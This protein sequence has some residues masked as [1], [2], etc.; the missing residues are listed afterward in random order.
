MLDR[1]EVHRD[2]EKIT[3]AWGEIDYVFP[4]LKGAR[5]HAGD[6]VGVI[7]HGASGLRY[8]HI[9]LGYKD[10]PEQRRG[11]AFIYEDSLLAGGRY[12]KLF[13]SRR[14][15]IP[16]DRW[17]YHKHSPLGRFWFCFRPK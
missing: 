7:V 14:C 12:E 5:F 6:R 3:R 17:Y 8:G 9:T 16:L 13:R 4:H 1:F 15:L 10:A 11:L 2:A